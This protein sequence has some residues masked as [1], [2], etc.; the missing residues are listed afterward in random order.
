MSDPLRL[1]VLVVAPAIGLGLFF[2]LA[3]RLIRGRHREFRENPE[4]RPTRRTIIVRVI[5]LDLVFLAFLT[6]FVIAGVWEAV[7]VGILGLAG[8][9]VVL[10]KV[11]SNYPDHPK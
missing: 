6:W 5:V 3:F 11:L 4:A 7:A 9:G 2:I 1:L 10:F 8:S